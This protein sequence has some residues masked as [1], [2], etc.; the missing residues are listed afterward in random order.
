MLHNRT[1]I[2]TSQI[3]GVS[4]LSQFSSLSNSTVFFDMEEETDYTIVLTNAENITFDGMQTALVCKSTLFQIDG[5]CKNIEICNFNAEAKNGYSPDFQCMTRNN[6]TIVRENIHIHDNY[7][8]CFSIAISLGAD[9]VLEPGEGVRYSK[10]HNNRIIG[11]QGT[12]AGTGYAI[13]MA[14][15]CYCDIFDNYIENS[16]RHAIYHAWG[17]NNIIKNNTI[18][19]HRKTVDFTNVSTGEIKG[20]IAVFRDSQNVLIENNIFID[21]YNT[22]IHIHSFPDLEYLNEALYADMYGITIKNNHFVNNGIHTVRISLSETTE[23]DYPSIMIGFNTYNPYT[24][25]NQYYI[26]DVTISGNIFE[27]LDTNCQQCIRMYE[28]SLLNII[29]NEFVFSHSSNISSSKF[30]FIIS[31]ETDY[32]DYTSFTTNNVRNTIATLNTHT[33]IHVYVLNELANFFITQNNRIKVKDNELINQRTSNGLTYRL[34][35]SYESQTD[36]TYHINA[37]LQTENSIEH[38]LPN[39]GYHIF[40]DLAFTNTISGIT[41]YRC[42]AAG[43]PG[44]WQTF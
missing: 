18:A 10:V 30:W 40:G 24:A 6:N 19:H 12:V 16:T 27:N 14:N 9:N 23:I 41:K 11:T 26:K 8:R 20:A 36:N 15:A 31:L 17:R 38:N 22:S 25:T 35:Y 32:K 43:N 5:G 44:Q 33:T 29:N 3:G 42:I 28:C 7:L 13:H 21:N 37:I 4:G 1:F 2:K 39:S 34:Y